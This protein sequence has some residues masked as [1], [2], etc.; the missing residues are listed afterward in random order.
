MGVDTKPAHK[1]NIGEHWVLIDPKFPK[2]KA[3]QLQSWF[4]EET[5]TYMF[6]L[7]SKNRILQDKLDS[8]QK[9]IKKFIEENNHE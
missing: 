7:V 1:L 3:E 5:T 6:D 8:M 2:E 9:S 4:N